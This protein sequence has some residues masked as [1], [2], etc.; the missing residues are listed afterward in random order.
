[1]NTDKR[2]IL[3]TPAVKGLEY[4]VWVP[5]DAGVAVPGYWML[6]AMDGNGV[7]SYAKT[8]LVTL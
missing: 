1:V 5:G 3:L 4:T 7:L 8:V 6:F 2:R